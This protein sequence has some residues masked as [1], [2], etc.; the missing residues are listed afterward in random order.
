MINIFQQES[1]HFQHEIILNLFYYF[2]IL[3]FF[4]LFH[5][6]INFYNII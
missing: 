5:K 4:G 2:I 3:C 6:I 1:K